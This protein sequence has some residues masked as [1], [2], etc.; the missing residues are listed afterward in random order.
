MR[1]YLL[2]ITPKLGTE[3]DRFSSEFSIYIVGYRAGHRVPFVQIKS[4]KK[5]NN[6]IVMKIDEAI[7]TIRI[8]S[9]CVGL[10]KMV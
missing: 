9:K 3:H 5:S 7:W 6:N 2:P 4:P 10:S 8:V 1:V